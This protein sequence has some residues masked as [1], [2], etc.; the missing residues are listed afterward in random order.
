MNDSLGS[1][2]NILG[3]GISA[4]HDA[5]LRG[6][7]KMP[8]ECVL[9]YNC[10][11]MP[12]NV[13]YDDNNLI[14]FPLRFFN[15]IVRCPTETIVNEHPV[16][17][18]PGRSSPSRR[19]PP[20][21]LPGSIERHREVCR[22]NYDHSSSNEK[23]S[24]SSSSSHTSPEKQPFYIHQQATNNKSS[25]SLHNPTTKFDS[26]DLHLI[27]FDQY[28]HKSSKRKSFEIDEDRF[29]EDSL[30]ESSLPPPPPPP[31]IPPPPSLSAPVTPSKRHSIA[32]E[33]N[34]DDSVS[35][36]EPHQVAASNKVCH[37]HSLFLSNPHNLHKQRR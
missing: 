2:R 10:I 31:V 27:T 37:P 26:N 5:V 34:L 11:P 16:T 29:S 18:Y 3:I 6:M 19:V 25:S 23:S 32:W 20:R 13:F 21:T 36:G 28:P 14:I 33:I 24:E 15:S 8:G 22:Q 35:L 7:A 4:V 12:I 9:I 17:I 30:E 1:G